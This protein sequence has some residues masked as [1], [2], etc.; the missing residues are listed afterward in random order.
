MD[1]QESLFQNI[2]EKLP[3]NI[4]FVHDISELLGISYDSA[5]RRIRGEKELTLDEFKKICTNYS[6]SADTLFN[7]HTGNI[8]FNARAIGFDGFTFEKWLGTILAELKVVHASKE[9]EVI[10]AAK[11]I[12][13]F[14]F[15][16]FPEIAAFKVYF[17][18]K[19]LFPDSGYEDKLFSFEVPEEMSSSGRHLMSMYRTMPTIELWNEETITSI[20]RQIEYC[21]VSCFFSKKED[22]IKLTEILETWV[23]HVQHQAEH[24]FRFKYGA[25]PKGIADTFRLY[26]NEVLLSDNTIL[27][28]MDGRKVTYLVYNIINL[29]VT[30]NPV[31]CS[32][33]E[34][35]L[36]IIMQKSTLISGT[37]AK[38]RNRFFNQLIE[39]IKTTRD[40]ITR[41]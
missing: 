8:I 37:S 10:Y 29:L 36:R 23:K 6:V 40:R 16:E 28:K 24:G 17:W 26:Y 7:V 35:S 9:R 14:H 5:Y 33:I 21:Y 13:L 34:N 30:A 41:S 31:F 12:P 15:F 11:D 19:A 3:A 32:Q 2:K 39:K 38:E 20:L 22:A 27:V 1:T 18:H 4:S 25:D